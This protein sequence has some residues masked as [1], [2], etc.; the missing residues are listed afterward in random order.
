MATPLRTKS[1][2]WCSPHRTRHG[3]FS[4]AINQHRSLGRKITVVTATNDRA[5]ALSGGS[6]AG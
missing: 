5:L 4:S 1:G 3:L 2:L 6:L